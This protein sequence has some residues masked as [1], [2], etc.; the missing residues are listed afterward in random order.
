MSPAAATR[1]L[2]NGR[3]KDRVARASY[4]LKDLMIAYRAE[5]RCDMAPNAPRRTLL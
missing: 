2:M 1:I 5:R 3:A 4:R